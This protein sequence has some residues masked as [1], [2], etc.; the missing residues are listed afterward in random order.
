[1]DSLT[2]SPDLEH[3]LSGLYVRGTMHE[4]A[5]GWA[6]LVA[7]PSEADTVENMLAFGILWLDWC[8]NHSDKRAVEGLRLFA[9]EG[10]TRALRERALALSPAAKTEIFEMREPDSVMQRID[11]GDAGNLESFLVPRSEMETAIAVTGETTARIRA[12]LPRNAAAITLRV[13]ARTGEVAFCFRGVEFAPRNRDGVFFGL[14]KSF[15]RLNTGSEPRLRK[16]LHDLDIHRSPLASDS[17]HRLYRGWPE[18]WLESIVVEDS[19]K[20][21]ALLDPKHF[22]SP[23]SRACGGRSRGSGSSWNYAPGPARGDRIESL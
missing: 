1:V 6:L 19:A 23:G 4:G 20:L 12:M 8:R 17:K 2:A 13:A 15:A 22:Y 16:L 11:S 14:G 3:S 7:G 18:R 5:R 21:D 10:T 9:P